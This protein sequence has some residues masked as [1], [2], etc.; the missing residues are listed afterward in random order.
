MKLI[1]I[2]TLIFFKILC[3]VEAIYGD[4]EDDV[5]LSMYESDAII[6]ARVK[7]VV[8]GKSFKISVSKVYKDLSKQLKPKKRL[9]V[10]RGEFSCNVKIQR[11]KKYVLTLKNT[12]GKLALSSK[13]RKQTKRLQKI[14]NQLTCDQCSLVPKIKQF[15]NS[16]SVKIYRWRNIK[17]RLSSGKEPTVTFSW[18]HNNKQIKQSEN[19]KI[20]SGRSGSVLNIRGLAETAGVYTCVA[21]SASG[22]DSCNTTLYV[23]G[24]VHSVCGAGY[25]LN[26]GTCAVVTVAPGELQPVCQCNVGYAGHRCELK[27]VNG[28]LSLNSVIISIGA[29]IIV[30]LI[31]MMVFMGNKLRRMEIIMRLSDKNIKNEL[32]AQKKLLS[33]KLNSQ[34][35][36]KR[37][38]NVCQNN[39]HDK[40]ELTR[41][42]QQQQ[43]QIQHQKQQLSK[44]ASS[45]V[46]V[47]N[48]NAGCL[49]SSQ[50]S[51]VS[52]TSIKQRRHH[53]SPETLTLQL[54]CASDATLDAQDPMS[55]VY[56]EPLTK[57]LQ[58]PNGN[59]A[60]CRAKEGIS[61]LYVEPVKNTL[62]PPGESDA[63]CLQAGTRVSPLYVD[64]WDRVDTCIHGTQIHED[65][66][67]CHIEL[68]NIVSQCDR[69]LKQM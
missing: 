35:G 48:S 21:S 37:F 61:P 66:E 42:H 32:S 4:C 69:Y 6:L 3:S 34:N 31:L 23:H 58:T 52:C 9:L 12:N 45:P 51:V 33:Q 26:S 2:Y 18:F 40:L 20:R 60:L 57:T 55:P 68:E 53:P 41:I 13:P 65:C 11:K 15:S 8:S 44:S 16:K 19:Y 27:H 7:R 46:V 30:L 14:I 67:K 28:S 22:Q 36:T 43:Q 56:V 38:T 29:V 1:L 24:D 17:C 63:S 47:L 25:C 59:D 10:L 54:P 39:I 5:S 62:K 50:S 64:P 49:T